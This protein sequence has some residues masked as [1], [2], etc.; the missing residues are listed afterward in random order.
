MRAVLK[1]VRRRGKD[2][3]L[4]V[5]V[6][7]PAGERPLHVTLPAAAYLAVGEIPE[8]TVLDRGMY[9]ALCAEADSR[10]CLKKTF[11]LLSLS[12]HSRRALTEK[13]RARGYLAA[14]VDAA[15]TEAVERGYLDEDAQLA[16]LRQLGEEKRR[17]ARYMYAALCRKGYRPEAVRAALD[18]YPDTAIR[19][20]ILVEEGPEALPR[21]G[22]A[23]E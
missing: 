6:S 5:A 11:D 9:E 10:A 3:L 16:R 17:S 23:P 15:V 8:G 7:A 13:L 4:C 22:F 12:P 21:H 14:S 19:A 20:A 2:V 18:G 1:Q